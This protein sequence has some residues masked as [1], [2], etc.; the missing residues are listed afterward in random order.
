VS[1]CNCPSTWTIALLSSHILLYVRTRA[2]LTRS[3]S[4]DT[5]V[6][7]MAD[8]RESSAD[9]SEWAGISDSGDDDMHY[10]VRLWRSLYLCCYLGTIADN[11]CSM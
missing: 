4:S 3:T 5:P 1:S 8:P 10:E 2:R 11:V 6:L 9:P 7:T